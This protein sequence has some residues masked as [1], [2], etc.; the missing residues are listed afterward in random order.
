M[1]WEEGKFRLDDPFPNIF[2]S[3]SKRVFE[4]A[5]ATPIQLLR[6]ARQKAKS[7]SAICLPY[8]RHW[9]WVLTVM[10]VLR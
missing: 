4:I 2:P 10:S 1:L 6:Q 5:F 3:L 7:L 8:F 9:L